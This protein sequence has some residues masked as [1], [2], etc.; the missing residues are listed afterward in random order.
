MNTLDV[1]DCSCWL[2]VF[3]PGGELVRKICSEKPIFHYTE[4]LDP[5]SLDPGTYHII[6]Q[7]KDQILVDKII[8]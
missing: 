3:K 8:V 6:I 1:D 7:Q 4:V 2:G 5:S